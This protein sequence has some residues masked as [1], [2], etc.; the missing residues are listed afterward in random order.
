MIL[1]A[2]QPTFMN[3]GIVPIVAVQSSRRRGRFAAQN[4][5]L[6]NAAPPYHQSTTPTPLAVELRP[7]LAVKVG[8]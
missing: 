4:S 3:F 8:C 2:G 1:E 7:S 5:G 6:T